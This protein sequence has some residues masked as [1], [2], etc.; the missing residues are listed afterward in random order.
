[1]LLRDHLSL[2]DNMKIKK[3]TISNIL[4]FAPAASPS[5]SG[6][7]FDA[8]GASGGLHIIIGPNGSGKSNF[9]EI[10]THCFKRHLFFPVEFN[11]PH[12]MTEQSGGQLDEEARRQTMKVGNN[13]GDWTLV[14]HREHSTEGQ[15]V[16]LL[17]QLNEN[18]F[19]NLEFLFD[20]REVINDLITRYGNSGVSVPANIDR[21]QLRQRTEIA[22]QIEHAGENPKST[23]TFVGEENVAV[24]FIKLYL[25]FFELFQHSITI[26][27]RYKK[28]ASEPE[29]PALKQTFALLGSYRNYAN[30]GSGVSVEANRS[31]QQVNQRL[32]NESTRTTD[33]QEPPVFELVKRK[34]AYR[35]YDLY[36]YHSLDDALQALYTEEPIASIN[37][38]L[39]KYLGLT[40]KAGKPNNIDPTLDIYF[41]RNG[42]ER[43]DTSELSS[44]EK[45]I[46]HFI[47]TL[48]GFD[49][50]SGSI[51]IDEPELHLHPQMQR[52]YLEIIEDI[53]QNFDIQFIIVT[54]SPIFVTSDTI[55]HVYRFSKVNGNTIVIKP[56]IAES[57]KSLAKILDLTSSAKIFFVDRALLVEGET[58]EYFWRF[59][60]DQLKR[61]SEETDAPPFQGITNFEIFSIKGKGER[62][63]WTDFL[64]KFG[65]R[66]SFLGDWDNIAEVASV[67]IRLYEEGCK[68]AAAKAAG[69]IQKK[70]SWDA[71]NLF[72]LIDAYVKAS[73]PAALTELNNFKN[74]ILSRHVKYA[75]LVEHI[76]TN[77]PTEWRAIERS[78]QDAY[79]QGIF[80]LQA[81]ELEDYIS[82]QGKGIDKVIEFCQQGYPHW[83]TDI[84]YEKHR[85]E[86]EGIISMIFS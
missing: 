53:R 50:K 7:M 69:E 57:Q 82:V 23:I 8:T 18:D 43:V 25:Q 38:L 66:V 85:K 27:N 58:D 54:H 70:G 2:I 46:L 9:V 73:S 75:K 72:A 33:G 60:L 48:Y 1:M 59:H 39:S 86:L 74:Y 42:G 17:L 79:K 51:M 21:E 67:D 84:K 15:S 28:Q 62:A 30:I 41:A 3:V 55:T 32:R 16:Q 20:N 63:T 11:E 76:E 22:I 29:W 80:I 56:N 68:Q 52:E 77:H 10:I 40:L 81:G 49:L 37:R 34:I 5:S 36:V 47:F 64:N 26:Y 35:F 65:L 31:F 83:L 19:A 6:I 44:G 71:I 14:R 45:G 13:Q 12:L 4:S 78:I 24:S 61:M